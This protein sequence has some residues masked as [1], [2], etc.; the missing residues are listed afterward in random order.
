MTELRCFQPPWRVVEFQ[1]AYRVEDVNGLAVAS[2]FFVEDPVRRGATGRLSKE[3]AWQ[4]AFRVAIM[5]DVESVLMGYGADCD[6]ARVS[7]AWAAQ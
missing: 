5:P 4:V 6:E 2:V 3:E 1:G 7:A